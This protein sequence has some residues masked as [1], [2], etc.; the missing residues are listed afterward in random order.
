MKGNGGT[1]RKDRKEG[2]QEGGSRCGEE[3]KLRGGMG[4]ASI[5]YLREGTRNRTWRSP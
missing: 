5:F 4:M 2:G 1:R 3:K